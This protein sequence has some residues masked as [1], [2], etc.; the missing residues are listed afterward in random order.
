MATARTQSD[1]WRASLTHSTKT[2][3]YG[4]AP[5]PPPASVLVDE[6]RER[7]MGVM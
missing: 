5:A 2:P 4:R 1:T 6:D 7:R 3:V